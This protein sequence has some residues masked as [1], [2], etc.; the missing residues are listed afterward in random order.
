VVADLQRTFAVDWRFAS[1]EHLLAEH[2]FPPLAPCGT[3][4]RADREAPLPARR[5]AACRAE[6][7]GF[8]RRRHG[9]R[10]AAAQQPA[11]DGLGAAPAAARIAGR[12]VPRPPSPPPFDHTKLLLVD[13]AWALLGST[14]WDARSLR[15]NFCFVR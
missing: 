6:G 1:G 13:G 10:A 12:R 8:A 14:N 2:W 11:R 15:L 9:H 3:V 7:A 5:A 4:E